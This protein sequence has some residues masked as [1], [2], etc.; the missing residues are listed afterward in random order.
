LLFYNFCRVHEARATLTMAAGVVDRILK[1]EDCHCVTDARHALANEVG[2][3]R[4]M[5]GLSAKTR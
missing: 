4:R 2:E 3:R 1:M 5:P